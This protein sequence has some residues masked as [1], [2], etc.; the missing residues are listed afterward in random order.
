MMHEIL[1]QIDNCARSIPKAAES[2]PHLHDELETLLVDLLVANRAARDKLRRDKEDRQRGDQWLRAD[3]ARV[4][5]LEQTEDGS[6]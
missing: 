2:C 4:E 1:Q 6:T 5:I 3:D